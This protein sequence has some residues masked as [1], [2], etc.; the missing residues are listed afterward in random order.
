MTKIVTR[1]APGERAASTVKAPDTRADL[2]A[3]VP[4]RPV[5]Q[6]TPHDDGKL[7]VV[8]TP[9]GEWQARSLLGLSTRG[10]SAFVS[11]G[12][13]QPIL[14]PAIAAPAE[15][16]VDLAAVDRTVRPGED[17]FLH[18]NGAWVKT[19][20]IPPERS[21]T[22]PHLRIIEEVERRTRAILEEA[23]AGSATKGT[24]EQQIGDYFASFMDEAVIEAKGIEPL[25]PTLSRIA[26][27]QDKQAL[28]AELGSGLR[29]DV[30]ALNSTEFY[31]D[32]VLGLWVEQDLNDP[33]RTAGYLL[34]GGLGMP[35][36]SYYLDDS[37]AIAAVRDAYKAHLGKMLELAGIADAQ[38]KAGRV[39]ELERKLAQAH[40]SRVESEDVRK[41]N[42]RWS[43]ADFEA[44]APGLDWTKFFHAAGLERESSFIVWHPT[45]VTGLG[46]LVESEPLETWKDY[47]TARAIEHAA[48]VLPKAFVDESFAFHGTALSGTPQQLERWKR[49]VAFTNGALGEAVGK[50]YVAR[51]FPPEAK[52]ELV[53]IVDNIKAAF[54]KRIDALTW[55]APQTK[56]QAK[57][58]LA[59]LE[60][61]I[62][63]PDFWRDFS[64]LE[65][66]RGDALGNFERAELFEYQ[67]SLAKLG[68]P[69]NRGEWVMTPQTVN[70]VNLPV[71]NALNFP[72]GFLEPPYY[73]RG[74]TAAVKYGAIG[75]TIGHE[76]S[77]SF[78]DQGAQF[79]ARGVLSNW[80]TAEDLAHFE[81]ATGRLADQ[82]SRYRPLPDLAVNGRQTL[83]ENVAD[84][85][86]LAAAYDAWRA[87]LN[88][89]PAPSVDGVTGE[90]QFFLSYAQ[91]WQSKMRE[92]AL[93]QSLLTDCHAPAQ[94]R[95]LTVRNLDPWYAAFDVKASEPFSLPA[96]ERVQVW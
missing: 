35:D 27:L 65:V 18:A 64:G 95:A 70:A 40:A 60:V 41:A 67:R 63:Y 7:D 52:C 25:R 2:P 89:T 86:G 10:A 15:R 3:S 20:E 85:A 34:Q 1:I 88:G 45:A 61:G 43:R 56:A 73:D 17:F 81:Q 59:A 74:T 44:K 19:A 46:A 49:G 78:D 33:T 42:N 79:D 28:A 23:G 16:G 58:K 9:A 5:P 21:S 12:P 96:G 32:H 90:Q 48:P 69:P 22:G 62:G 57:A 87:S 93:R 24:I 4:E 80:W 82:F 8:S 13:A 30:D 66:V 29:A 39:F 83:S 68:K 26:Q 54:A 76:I 91:S 31:T 11:R 50:L 72:A 71:R 77:H 37:P 75:A 53:Q 84:L 38:A 6:S 14:A 92:Q 94:Y 47:L 51:H 36:R 55:M